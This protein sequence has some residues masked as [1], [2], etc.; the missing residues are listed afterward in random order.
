MRS[1]RRVL[2]T[3]ASVVAL[4][5]TVVV[6]G[7][8]SAV[9]T[10]APVLVPVTLT[11][12]TT[13]GTPNGSQ[14]HFHNG[15]NA[16]CLSNNSGFAI[17]EADLDGLS[18]ARPGTGAA[19]LT[20]GMMLFDPDPTPLTGLY[21]EPNDTVDVV[22][23]ELTTSTA[24]LGPL[25]VSLQHRTMQD[26]NRL[27]S[28][29][30]FANPSDAPV[31]HHYEMRSNLGSG[32]STGVRGTSSGD[33]TWAP[34]DRWLVTSDAAASAQLGGAALTTALYGPGAGV[35]APSTVSF[36]CAGPDPDPHQGH[37]VTG[38]DVTVPAHASRSLVFFSEL[39]DTNEG[40]VTAAASTY[41]PTTFTTS[42][43][44]S[45]LSAAEKSGILNWDLQPA[46]S[47]AFHA[48]VPYRVLDSRSAVGG[49]GAQKLGPGET[50]SLSVAGTGGVGGMPVSATAVVLNVTATEGTNGS[51]VTVFPAGA[52]RAAPSNLNFAPYETIPNLATTALGAGGAL[53]VYNAVGS[54][55]L[56]ADVVGYFDDGAVPGSLFNGI[57][58]TRVLDSRGPVGGWNGAKLGPGASRDLVVRGGTTGVP[59]TATAVVMNVTATDG[60]AG[61][62]LR[63]WPK[64]A[65][66]PIT[67]NVNFGAGQTIANLVT[68]QVGAAD[69][70]SILNAAGATHVVADITGYFDPS[71]GGGRFHPI[72][73]LRILESRPPAPKG[74]V[75]PLGPGV[76]KSLLVAGATPTIPANATGVILNVT[77]TGGTTGSLLKVYPDGAAPPASSTV[78]FGAGQTIPNLTMLSLPPNGKLAL[79]NQLGTVHVIGDAAGYFAAT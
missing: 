49:W 9:A 55:H 50:R 60:S 20:G 1:S 67:S 22:G 66:P 12:G 8:P 38:W 25:N 26:A 78:N 76:A 24:P 73:P 77:V 16:Q 46:P 59:G 61:S 54:V 6:G 27:R 42:P 18:D 51:F 47:T 37:Q 5:A 56:I 43:I 23:D 45:D 79:L 63:V 21:F 11:A 53:S 57:T 2:T 17:E 3:A 74:I 64:G 36:S 48:V 44:F 52:A 4:G 10:A 7:L 32:P 40:A 41:D 70:V 71:A 28:T 31:T 34:A 29:Y 62:F 19:V 65:A 68:V 15:A 30:T 13:A 39:H 33:T 72:E 58:P 69:A 14:W 75:G 35:L